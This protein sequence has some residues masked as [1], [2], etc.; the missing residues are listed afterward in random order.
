MAIHHKAF[1]KAFGATS[2]FRP[3]PPGG[4]S[5]SFSM[6]SHRCLDPQPRRF[7]IFINIAKKEK[8]SKGD[9]KPGPKSWKFL[10]VNHFSVQALERVLSCWWG[11][12]IPEVGVVH[13]PLFGLLFM[14]DINSYLGFTRGPML[15]PLTA[16]VS[17][18]IP[19]SNMSVCHS[20][21][22]ML[23]LEAHWVRTIPCVHCSLAHHFQPIPGNTRPIPSFHDI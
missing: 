15:I 13:T 22:D 11:W 5:M 2:S 7:R 9:K 8:P 3:R 14:C 19:G 4:M 21:K 16:R 1:V 18:L 23:T 10:K 12:L 17:I 20:S 6:D